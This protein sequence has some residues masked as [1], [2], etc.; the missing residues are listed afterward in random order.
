MH[1]T[2]DEVKFDLKLFSSQTE[3]LLRLLKKFSEQLDLES[4][5]I[6]K[7]LADQILKTTANKQELADK[8][9]SETS[10]LNFN[11]EKSGLNL[12]TLVESQLFKTLPKDL[13]Q[14]TQALISLVQECHDKNLANGMSIQ[15]LSNIN[16]HALDLISG[17]HKQD[18]KLYGSSGEKTQ[19]GNQSSLGKA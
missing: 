4:E 10:A 12:N 19:S 2:S 9:N 8:L 14:Q 11:L 7:N 15:M 18:I 13:Q 6:R 17:K 5:S 16:Q 1:P 3:S